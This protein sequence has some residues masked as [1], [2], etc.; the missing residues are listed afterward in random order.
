MRSAFAHPWMVAAFVA[1]LLPIIIEW[2]FRRRR[3][4]VELP[5]IRFLLRNK[6]QKKVKRQDR[7]LLMVR[8][9]GIFFLVLA[10]A[11]PLIRRGLGGSSRRHVVVVLDGTGSMNQQVGITTAFSL[12]QKKASAMVRGV[13]AGAVV[14]VV[15]LGD[16]AETVLERET[17]AQTAAARIE[18]LRCGSGAAPMAVA[19]ESTK[20][21]LA[22][23]REETPEICIFS[24]FQKHTWATDNNASRVVS[25]TLN[26]LSSQSETFLVD[27]GGKPAFNYMLTDLRPEEYLMSAG[28]PVR[29]RCAVESWRPPKDAKATVT[30]LVNGVKKDVR[31][32]QP[33]EQ[34]LSITFEH[35]FTQPGEYLVEAVL[36]GDEYRMDNHRYCLCTVPENVQVLVLDESAPA[37][38]PGAADGAEAVAD[39]AYFARALAPP[40]HPG[41]ERVSRFSV[42]VV[43][44][45][46]LDFE[47]IDKYAAVVLAGVGAVGEPAAAK[48]ESYVAEGGALWLF[49][50]P[51]VDLYQY[52]KVL[53]KEGK[54]VLPCRLT[55]ASA[56]QPVNGEPPHLRFGDST[57]PALASLTGA[58]SADARFLQYMG[59]EVPGDARVVMALSNGAPVLVEKPFG[60]GKVLLADFTAGLGWTYLPATAEFPILMQELMRYLIGNPD[61]SVNLSVGDRFEQPV[62]VST[63]HLLV[64]YP[65]GHKA[66]LTPHERADRKNAWVL[67]LEDT[68]QQGLYEVVDAPAEVMP[69]LRFVVN[70][71]PAGGDLSRFDR[72]ELADALG[73]GNWRWIA[74]ESSFDEL[75]SRR[76]EVT[77]LAPAVLWGLALVLGGESLL[78]MY[79]G[80]RRGGVAA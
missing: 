29:F 9:L 47:N 35:R 54:G 56:T 55:A 76:L 78:A 22:R 20:D 66:R 17:D 64:R 38:A 31:E 37:S 23:G 11:R 14:S 40:T 44:P 67:S 25:Q 6:E 73:H 24:D 1:V 8:M 45:S 79:F 63:Q 69:R 80:R 49:L 16:K 46:Q 33:G 3:R 48:L 58:G 27:V 53:F 18:S 26:S 15:L 30:F 65:D 12:A 42:K 60:R 62:F 74:P 5:T 70:Q 59:L 68:R 4:R 10:I 19:L 77:E 43:Q 41:A 51:R 34:S 61:T 2:L 13:P 28:M 32:V 21:L 75:V 52:N 7:I 57:H 71:K 39:S 72:D 50:G 36:E